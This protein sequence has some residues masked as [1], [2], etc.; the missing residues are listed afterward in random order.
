[1]ELGTT[2]PPS[3]NLIMESI[4]LGNLAVWRHPAKGTAKGLVL[5]IHGISEHSARHLNTIN[6]LTEN[7]W[8][9]VR[10]DLRG[11]GE[12]GGRRQWV[13]KF[14]H[15]V[16]D[17][18]AVFNWLNRTPSTLP[19]FVLGHSLGGAIAIYFAAKYHRELKGLVLSAPAFKIGPGIS[20][21]KIIVGRAL[22]KIVP[23]LRMPGSE[24]IWISRDPEVVK[25]YKNDP[26]SCHNNTIQQGTVILDALELIPDQCE[27]I[28]CPTFIVHGTHDRTIPLE[29][30]FEIMESLSSSDRTLMVIPGG[31]HEPHNDWDKEYFFSQLGLWLNKTASA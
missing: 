2:L 26:L 17:T 7:D 19:V 30:S 22:S 23:T 29:G 3:Y 28:E 12:S 24:P 25:A 21:A 20:P 16:D 6:F 8:E 1:M 4:H 9:V 5:L 10:F 14:D 15:Y 31:Y 13:D 11:A 27:L 18:A